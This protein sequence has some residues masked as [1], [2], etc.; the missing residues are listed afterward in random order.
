MITIDSCIFVSKSKQDQVVIE[1]VINNSSL[2]PL[3]LN[4]SD[5]IKLYLES[6]DEVKNSKC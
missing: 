2:Q 6:M 3:S 5:G 4:S 1:W